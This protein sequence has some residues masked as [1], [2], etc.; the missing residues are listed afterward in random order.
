M[1]QA[2]SDALLSSFLGLKKG[3]SFFSTGKT[4]SKADDKVIEISGKNIRKKYDL[5][6]PV[7]DLGRAADCSLAEEVLGWKPKIG[8]DEGLRMTYQWASQFLKTQQIKQ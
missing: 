1:K 8:L 6:K 7:G 2:K 5:T 3:T 4:N